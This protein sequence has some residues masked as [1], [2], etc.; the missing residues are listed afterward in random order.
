MER[1]S[2]GVD[3]RIAY[4]YHD[5][6]KH[7]YASVRA[8]WHHLDWRNKPLQEKIYIDLEKITLPEAFP[9]PERPVYEVLSAPRLASGGGGI[10]L[11]ELTSILYFSA[12][13]TRRLRVGGEYFWFRA[14]PSA[15]ALYPIELYVVCGDMRGLDAGVYHFNPVGFY[16]TRIREGDYRGYLSTAAG[17]ET[18]ASRPLSIIYS[19]IF[20]R[21]A[22]KYRARSYRYCFWDAGTILSNSTAVCFSL[23]LD[24]KIYTGFCDDDVN[25][26]IGIDGR[27]EAALAVLSVGG[28]TKEAPMIP[29]ISEI[30][31]RTRPLSAKTVEYPEIQAL[32]EA[33]KLSSGA[34]AAEWRTRLSDKPGKRLDNYEHTALPTYDPLR[35]PQLPLGEVIKRRGSTRVFSRSPIEAWQLS[36][37]LHSSRLGI[38]ADFNRWGRVVLNDVYLIVNAVN[39]I[40]SGAYFFDAERG[41]L[42][43]LRKGNYREMAGYLCLEQELGRDAAA[44][45]FMSCDLDWVLG[46]LG[47]RGYRAAQLEAGMI[48]G[49]IYLA[50]YGLG[51]GATGLTFYDDDVTEFFS[52]HASNK[53]CMFIVASGH[54]AYGGTR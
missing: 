47:N 2:R 48:G 46:S 6:T 17:D 5:S 8:G 16:L 4:E 36:A 20:W 26:L 25:R 3:P 14:S 52:P 37:L 10:G 21:S 35:L 30:S 40:E 12:G 13:L 53:S 23:G 9:F 51:I 44:V 24:A 27:E 43:R 7:S 18:L 41:G 54:P 39:G 45:F 1:P 32:H 19:A 31:P 15:G 29:K 49:R 34:E 28:D 22:W 11:E 38:D 33:S 42:L 50:S